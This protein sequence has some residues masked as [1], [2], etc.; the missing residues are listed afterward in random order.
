[1]T[2]TPCHQSHFFIS[3]RQNL[4]KKFAGVK[5]DKISFSVIPNSKI[6]LENFHDR[7][8]N[9][10]RPNLHVSWFHFLE[11]GGLGGHFNLSGF[12]GC[13]SRFLKIL[14]G[15]KLGVVKQQMMQ[16]WSNSVDPH[17]PW[18]PQ[19]S[20]TMALKWLTPLNLLV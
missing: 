12:H 10:N 7:A 4:K 9:K 5:V 3:L 16:V 14:L 2:K 8:S 20:L 6:Y 17:F 13:H 1:M 19:F 15:Y 11:M 18:N